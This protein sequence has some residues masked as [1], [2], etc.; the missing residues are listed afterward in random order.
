MKNNFEK[1]V[2]LKCNHCGSTE[3]F[4]NE[5]DSYGKCNSCGQEFSGGKNE[6]LQLN[7]KRIEL[8]KNE[9]VKDVTDE[10]INSLKKSFKGNK[11]IKFN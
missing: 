9:L 8:S 5:I 1:I 11:F 7:S 3:L 10:F 6:I 2:T 4:L